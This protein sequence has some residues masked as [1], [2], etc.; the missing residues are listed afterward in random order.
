MDVS[1]II[2]AR[3]YDFSAETVAV[4]DYT[5]WRFLSP[6]AGKKLVKMH[7]GPLR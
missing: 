5:R 7:D 6:V 1:E 2:A 4:Y 3:R